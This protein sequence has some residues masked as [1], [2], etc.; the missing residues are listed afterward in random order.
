MKC[1]EAALQMLFRRAACR[2]LRHLQYR[3]TDVE[4]EKGSGSYGNTLTLRWER[5]ERRVRAK[6][7]GDVPVMVPRLRGNVER[8]TPRRLAHFWFARL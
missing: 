3:Y 2:G 1:G 8:S 4:G 7:T 6:W 5:Y